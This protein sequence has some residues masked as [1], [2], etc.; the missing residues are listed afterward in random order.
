M[1]SQDRE[2]LSDYLETLA[3]RFYGYEI[4]ERLESAG[5]LTVE[6]IIAALEDYIIEGQEYLND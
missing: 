5:I 4:V 6:Q 3:S 2:L 1:M